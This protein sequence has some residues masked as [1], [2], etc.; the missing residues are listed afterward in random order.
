MENLGTILI[1]DS[2]AD[3]RK[4]CEISFGKSFDVVGLAGDGVEAIRL[5]NSQKPDVVVLDLWLSKRDG[6][7]VIEEF[8]DKADK[9]VFI[10]ATSVSNM[11]MLKDASS[12]GAAYCVRK[13]F[14]FAELTDRIA[15]ILKGSKPNPASYTDIEQQVTDVIHLVG[16]P[17]HIK[18]YNYLRTAIML[19]LKDT[20]ALESVTK[21]LYPLVAKMYQ[22]SPSRVERAIRHAIEVAWDRGDLETLNSMFGYTVQNSRGKPTNSEFIAL[23]SDNLRIKNKL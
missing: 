11:N 4:E 3:Y 14:N 16:I 21:V 1:A 2:D 9:P 5:I 12:K 19:V 7:G 10:V 6:I 13:P 23:I 17:A 20:G 8:A 15:E 18:G 22:T